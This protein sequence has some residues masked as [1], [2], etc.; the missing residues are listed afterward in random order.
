MVGSK[1]REQPLAHML[2]AGLRVA[3]VASL[4]RIWQWQSSVVMGLPLLK[5]FVQCLLLFLG[6][7]C[8]ASINKAHNIL[9]KAVGFVIG[10]VKCFSL[11]YVQIVFA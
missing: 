4:E 10:I 1:V 8:N 7:D 2:S 5:V 9:Q 11:G 3:P 6:T